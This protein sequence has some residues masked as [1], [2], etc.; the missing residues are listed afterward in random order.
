MR[1][2]IGRTSCLHRFCFFPTTILVWVLLSLPC[3]GRTQSNGG[4]TLCHVG[5]VSGNE[6]R[7]NRCTNVG[8]ADVT[9]SVSS[10]SAASRAKRKRSA[11]SSKNLSTAAAHRNER[12]LVRG[13]EAT[14]NPERVFWECL[15]TGTRIKR[16][17]EHGLVLWIVP[18]AACI[19]SFETFPRMSHCLYQAMQLAS[20]Q[21]WTPPN[22]EQV[23]LQT[24]VV[25][26]SVVDFVLNKHRFA[27]FVFCSMVL[28][29]L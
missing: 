14:K 3:M 1:A 8:V 15:P 20:Q 11:M 18:V 6:M 16:W 28:K 9:S 13:G 12:I 29:L 21:A 19:I 5:S 2:T 22:K 4:G 24:N 17:H 26:R 10:T 25:V 27:L 23:D 7:R